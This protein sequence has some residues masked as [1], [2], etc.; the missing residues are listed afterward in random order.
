MAIRAM[1]HYG[2]DARTTTRY[3]SIGESA[4]GG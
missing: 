4:R 2:Q 3:N 1:L